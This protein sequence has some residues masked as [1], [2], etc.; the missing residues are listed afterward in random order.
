MS[1]RELIKQIK[2]LINSGGLPVGDQVP[3]FWEYK[4]GYYI[5]GDLKLTE[6]EFEKL[7]AKYPCYPDKVT[8]IVY[9][10]PESQ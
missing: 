4:D 9:V 1:K 8:A 3:L 2:E 5:S 6:A 7:N 10:P